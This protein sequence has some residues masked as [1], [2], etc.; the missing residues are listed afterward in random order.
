[1]FLFTAFS[2]FFVIFSF[3]PIR[4]HRC[5]CF[6]SSVEFVVEDSGG[7]AIRLVFSV[8]CFGEEN[9]SKHQNDSVTMNKLKE[10]ATSR[11]KKSTGSKATAKKMFDASGRPRLPKV[12]RSNTPM[13]SLSASFRLLED[14]LRARVI[15]FI[16][17]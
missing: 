3:V 12:L 4:S 14:I 11:L 16:L 13:V 2:I 9:R 15:D 17:F 8:R 6:L 10:V 5:R 1:M 7:I